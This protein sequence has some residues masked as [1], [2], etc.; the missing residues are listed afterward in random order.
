MKHTREEGSILIGSLILMGIVL[1]ICV[2]VVQMVGRELVFAVDVLQ[3]ER[4]YYAAESGVEHTLLV[5]RQEPVEYY[6][7]VTIALGSGANIRVNIENRVDEYSVELAP[8][9]AIKFLLRK[10][11]DNT[12]ATAL[13]PVGDFTLEADNESGTYDTN[14]FAWKYIC[15]RGT[16]TIALQGRAATGSYSSFAA[17]RGNLDDETNSFAIPNKSFADITTGGSTALALGSGGNLTTAEQA[18]CFFSATNT[19]EMETLTLTF[20]NSLS[21]APPVAKVVAVG[22]AGSREKVV[23]FE[24]AQKNL[25]GLFDILFFHTQEGL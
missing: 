13:V 3:S 14:A 9:E 23:S 7:D 17:E 5:L 10:D 18:G 25:G 4:A 16:R 2:G 20:Q 24:Y 6:E 1:S 12:D 22:S 15:P 21:F 8:G 19:S 11:T